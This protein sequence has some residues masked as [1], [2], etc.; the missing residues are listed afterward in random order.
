MIGTNGCRRVLLHRMVSSC[1][2]PALALVMPDW[3]RVSSQDTPGQTSGPEAKGIMSRLKVYYWL[4]EWK[5]LRVRWEKKPRS[6]THT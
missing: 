2:A 3:R 5:M 6:V 1:P 4:S